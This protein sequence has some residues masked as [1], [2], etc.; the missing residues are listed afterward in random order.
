M[1]K[2]R[3]CGEVDPVKFY[4]SN[5][6]NCKECVKSRVKKHREE[7]IERVREYD[8][9]RPNAKDRNKNNKDRYKENIKDPDYRRKDL[10]RTKI[11]QEKNHVK[12][13]AHII[14]GNAIRDGRLIKK[15]CEICG[16][17]NVDGHHDDYE[18]PL[19]VRWLCRKHH[20]EHHKQDR[21][22]ERVHENP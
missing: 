17:A 21:E 6:S 22:Q 7:N 20:A 19:E 4:A 15:P 14:V 1:C 2:C 12:R 5:K 10:I 16:E 11:W 8:R 9:H 18:K 13:A 3:V